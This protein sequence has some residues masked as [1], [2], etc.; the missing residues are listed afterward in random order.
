VDTDLIGRT[1]RVL[2]L[3]C[4]AL[5]LSACDLLFPIPPPDTP[6]QLAAV[7]NSNRQVTLTWGL[8]G[9]AATG[10][11]V[12][13]ADA[14]GVFT[15]VANLPGASLDFI[16]SSVAPATAYQYRVQAC[17]SSG[18]SAF[19]GP[20]AVT[21]FAT[22]VITTSA[23]AG[24]VV[25]DALTTT[26][27]STGGNPPVTFA[28][29]AGSLPTG[30]TLSPAGM[31]AGA[32]TATGSF[33]ITVRATS[34]D[35]QTASV[36]LVLVVRA[37]LAITTTALPNAVR[38]QFYS[39]GLAA[40]GADGAYTWLVE[41]GS[42]PAGV[43]LSNA[44]IISGTPTTEQVARFT[45][46]VRS[47]D[48]Q[49]AARDFAITVTAPPTGGPALS[50]RN[51]VL[52]PALA[53]QTYTPLLSSAGGDGSAVSWSIAAGSLPPGVA[54]SAGGSFS[55]RATSAGTFPLTIRASN[56]SGQT[57]DKAFSIS[58]VAEDASRF[59]ITRMDV[60]T[61]PANI[62]PH[63]AAAIARWETVIT[64]D[65]TRDDIPRGFFSGPLCGGFGEWVNGTFL[66]D[67][68]VMI[69]I[70]PIDGPGQILGQA[71]PCSI[72]FNV[73]T[74]VGYLQLDAD[75][76][77]RFA[78]TQTLTDIIFHEI[79]HIL[80][81][82]TIW[83][84]FECPARPPF[85]TCWDYLTGVGATGTSDPRFGGPRAVP[86]WQALG[87]MG[88]VPVENQGGPGT[89]DSHWRESIFT[90]E[91][92]TGF[93]SALGVTNPLSRVTIASMADLGYVVNMG[94]ADTF[95]LGAPPAS[96]RLGIEGEWEELDLGPIL[97]KL[98]DGSKR[99]IPR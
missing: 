88:N 74:E 19:A 30:V 15:Q 37:R 84:G 54:L 95:R 5:A 1:S 35:Q 22:L 68:I 46:R 43:S 85:T 55:G 99:T 59:N 97:M 44:G 62:A 38:G 18:C 90:T 3:G 50:I 94:A 6:A 32:P 66:D 79:G 77:S 42:L 56:T 67:I 34:A 45:A 80:G 51:V 29:A 23:L 58:V 49:S 21:T 57:V 86:E 78:G 16:D 48:G 17:N 36:D 92:M 11:K 40:A 25:G 93:V 71:T 20:V 24:A 89:K 65:L 52:P 8:S 64:G 60:S 75:D 10:V 4:A 98:P 39:T 96:L 14:S 26:I 81:F 87:G 83:A 13:R 33:A 47:G 76:L 41:T 70:G 53:N 72:R 63:V 69:Q 27:Q 9:E 73:L 82:G 91:M 31:L 7:P 12:E 28:V 61:V 2:C